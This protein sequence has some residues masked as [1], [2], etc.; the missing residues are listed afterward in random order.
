MVFGEIDRCGLRGANR[1]LCDLG[2]GN[3]AF[4][5][6][7]SKRGYHVVGLDPSVTGIAVAQATY[8]SPQVEFHLASGYDNLAERF[9][10]FPL[11]VSLEVIEHLYF[12][13]KFAECAF[14]LLEVGGTAILSTPYHGYW[15]NLAL[16]VSGKLDDHFTALW[17]NG[18]IKF[19]SIKTLH[20]LLTEA[21]FC[22]IRF[23][24]VGR[25]PALAKSMVAIGRRA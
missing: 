24:K 6:E 25:V 15:K 1:R 4:A 16:A 9:G 18:H 5:S 14:A 13:R 17:D 8:A 12:P 3:G 21:G 23:R 2:C 10:R 20:R 19:W 11:V 7:L 22:D